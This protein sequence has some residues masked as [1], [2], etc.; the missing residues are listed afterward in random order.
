MARDFCRLERRQS[1]LLP[2]DMQDW[3]PQDDIVHLVLDA[4]SLMDLSKY[5]EEHH[6]GT[7]GHDGDGSNPGALPPPVPIRAVLSA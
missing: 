4:V 2:P 7:V 3:V 6:V 1:F 5:E